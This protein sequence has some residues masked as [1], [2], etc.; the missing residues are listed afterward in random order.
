MNKEPE[1]YILTHPECG[2]CKTIKE[3]LKEDIET[4][5]LGIIDISTDEGY[6]IAMD[7]GADSVPS[8]VEKDVKGEY[9]LCKL[10]ELV[11]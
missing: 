11:K 3:T 7:I 10:E 9:K 2:F 5:K 6:K 4:G 8:C 1:K